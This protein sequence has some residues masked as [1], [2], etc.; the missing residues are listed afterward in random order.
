MAGGKNKNP[1][2]LS[3]AATASRCRRAKVTLDVKP[4]WGVLCLQD[5]KG[6]G[7]VRVARV[8]NDIG[9]FKESSEPAVVN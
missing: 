2:A 3:I 6:I 5:P 8:N 1:P 7:F 9:L 4:L